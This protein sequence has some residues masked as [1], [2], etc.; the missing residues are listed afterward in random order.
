[1]KAKRKYGSDDRYTPLYLTHVIFHSLKIDTRDVG[2]TIL[3]VPTSLYLKKLENCSVAYENLLILT[4]LSTLYRM[5]SSFDLDNLLRIE[6]YDSN[7]I[8]IIKKYLQLVIPHCFK[9]IFKSI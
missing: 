9:S 1:M 7:I 5:W 8:Q 3:K 4:S 2:G 6:L